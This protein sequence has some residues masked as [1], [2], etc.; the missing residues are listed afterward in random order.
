MAAVV[1]ALLGGWTIAAQAA[2]PAARPTACSM[3]S[4][5]E[6]SAI[7]GGAVG[8]PVGKQGSDTTECRYSPAKENA[9]SPYAQVAIDWDSGPEAMAGS[10]LAAKMMGKDAGFSISEPIEGLGDEASSMIGGVTN[11]RKGRTFIQVTLGGQSH[12][13]EKG[14]AIA[15]LILSRI[16]SAGR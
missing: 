5:A 4:Q 16:E 9:I 15:K 12:S 14:T 6:M 3:V 13:K 10:K 11:V 8:T 2:G 7:L 1:G